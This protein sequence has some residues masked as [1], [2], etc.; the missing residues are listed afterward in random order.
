M[1]KTQYAELAIGLANLVSPTG[2]VSDSARDAIMTKTAKG[3]F[4]GAISYITGTPQ[5][6]TT[7]AVIQNLVDS[8]DRQ[9][10]TATRNREAALQNMR[11]QAPTDLEQSRIDKLN[12]STEM[13]GYEGQNRISKANVDSYIKANPA[14]AESV[15]KLY[16]VPGATDKD[17]EDYLKA[18]GKLQ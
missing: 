14:E 1:P 10:Q 4:N 13:V 11:D 16:E 17:I 3:D 8:V 18:Q 6:G 2:S 7:Q 9:A 12:K 5:N 15:A